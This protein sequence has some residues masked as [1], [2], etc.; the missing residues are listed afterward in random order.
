MTKK[1]LIQSRELENAA[2]KAGGY[3]ASPGSL[4]DNPAGMREFS[5]IRRYSI[6]EKKPISQLTEEDYRKIGIRH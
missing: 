2:E 6:Q 4:R 1:V 5:A 3:V